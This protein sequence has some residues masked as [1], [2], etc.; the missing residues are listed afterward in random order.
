M[1]HALVFNIDQQQDQKVFINVNTEIGSYSEQHFGAKAFAEQ[2]QGLKDKEI[3]MRI[4]SPGGA[5]ADA[6]QIY[7]LLSQHPKPV[8]TETYGATASAATIIAQ[9]GH[10]VISE[11]ALYLV[12]HAWALS[13]GNRFDMASMAKDLEKF[14][15]RIMGIYEAKGANMKKVKGY[16]SK[17]GGHGQWLE[18]KQAL[19][20][21]LV[22]EIQ[23]STHAKAYFSPELFK[24][25]KLP[26]LPT[27][28]VERAQA[29]NVKPRKKPEVVKHKKI[30][31]LIEHP[32]IYR[33]NHGY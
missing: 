14:D 4:N 33:N 21:G 5:V 1:N 10:R 23:K 25:L 17:N 13:M 8:R 2:L 15:N 28:F 3:V 29:V 6:L 7:D 31:R 12:H 16:M 9:A 18:P 19:E 32:N 20:A 27:D 22:D 26:Q 30:S 24:T 11:N